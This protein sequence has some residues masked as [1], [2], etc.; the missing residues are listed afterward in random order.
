MTGH[1]D[2]APGQ[3]L[4]ESLLHA[5]NN[6][7]PISNVRIQIVGK[8]DARVLDYAPVTSLSFNSKFPSCSPFKTPLPSSVSSGFPSG[9]VA[10]EKNRGCQ[11]TPSSSLCFA[12]CLCLSSSSCLRVVA[13][14]YWREVIASVTPDQNFRDSLGS[15]S[16]FGGRSLGATE[17][18][19]RSI[20]R[21]C[22][23]CGYVSGYSCSR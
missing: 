7:N 15:W 11:S 6:R 9:V 20:R 21:V 2:K 13:R 17:R 14:A 23:L 22:V 4:R 18:G 5:C 8:R 1:R 16:S 19:L 3:M 12:F 10:A